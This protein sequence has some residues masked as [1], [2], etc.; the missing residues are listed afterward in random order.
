MKIIFILSLVSL[1]VFAVT[2]VIKE[3]RYSRLIRY[4]SCAVTVV[5]ALVAGIAESYLLPL[6]IGV[7]IFSAVSLGL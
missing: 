4:A 2:S 5:F 3:R 6:S 1:L 7:A